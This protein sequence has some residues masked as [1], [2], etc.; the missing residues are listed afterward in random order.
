[1]LINSSESATSDHSLEIFNDIM[2]QLQ[3]RKLIRHKPERVR[4]TFKIVKADQ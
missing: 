3:E 2:S 4:Q 1:M